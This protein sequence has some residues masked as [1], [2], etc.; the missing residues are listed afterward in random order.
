MS[1]VY[2]QEFLNRIRSEEQEERNRRVRE[3]GEQRRR[4]LEIKRQQ[5]QDE[6]KK[7]TA[8]RLAPTVEKRPPFMVI[9]EP[10]HSYRKYFKQRLRRRR[11]RKELNDFFV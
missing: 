2:G 8:T 9:S 6:S 5:D 4:Q 1:K 3:E 7:R 10:F 11:F